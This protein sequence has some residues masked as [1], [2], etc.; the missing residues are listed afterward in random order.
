M[1]LRISNGA[2]KMRRMEP[3]L[4]GGYVIRSTNFALAAGG[5][6]AKV[7]VEKHGGG[8]NVS[9]VQSFDFPDSFETEGAADDAA[10]RT[11]MQLIDG[12][13]EGLTI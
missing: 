3:V 6:S 11:G 2:G 5:F 4:Y 10:L 13:V 9:S 1:E 12:T 7:F 8:S